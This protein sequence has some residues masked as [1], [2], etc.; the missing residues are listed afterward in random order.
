MICTNE[1]KKIIIIYD[2]KGTKIIILFIF[3][4]III[5]LIFFHIT[6]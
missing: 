1:H 2:V 4:Y 5:L 3:I 6:L